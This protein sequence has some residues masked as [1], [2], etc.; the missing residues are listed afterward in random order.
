M[1]RIGAND[2]PRLAI[3]IVPALILSRRAGF[4][5]TTIWHLA[6]G[7]VF[8]QL[9]IALLLLRDMVA[10][11]GRCRGLSGRLGQLPVR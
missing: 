2:A 6:A 11:C 4:A 7:A 1:L 3:A 5:L 8:V 9:G 10:V